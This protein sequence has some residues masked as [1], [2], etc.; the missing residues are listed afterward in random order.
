MGNVT[1]RLG[2]DVLHMFRTWGTPCEQ[3]VFPCTG[4]KSRELAQQLST[5]TV[6][7]GYLSARS[8]AWELALDPLSRSG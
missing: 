6:D 3:V 8:S 1:K 4:C 5:V 2:R 7:D